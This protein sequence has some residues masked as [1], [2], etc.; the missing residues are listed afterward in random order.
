[1]MPLDAQNI[2]VTPAQAEK[3][4]ALQQAYGY[5]GFSVAQAMALFGNKNLRSVVSSLSN[6][7]MKGAL[8]RPYGGSLYARTLAQILIAPKS[9]AEHVPETVRPDNP[10]RIVFG[11]I[12]NIERALAWLKLFGVSVEAKGD[13]YIIDGRQPAT[14]EQLIVIA[15]RRRTNKEKYANSERRRYAVPTA[16]ADPAPALRMRQR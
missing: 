4:K 10:E 2:F 3:L 6:L 9:I 1:M 11:P 8:E 14:A 13:R 12:Q 5:R 16:I 15:E 7:V